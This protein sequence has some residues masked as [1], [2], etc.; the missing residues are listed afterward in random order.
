MYCPV[1]TEHHTLWWVS[2]GFPGILSSHPVSVGSFRADNREASP[3]V[4]S[5]SRPHHKT[6]PGSRFHGLQASHIVLTVKLLSVR[7]MANLTKECLRS[8]VTGDSDRF[9]SEK[10]VCVCVC[11][12]VYMCVWLYDSVSTVYACVWTACVFSSEALLWHNNVIKRKTPWGRWLWLFY[13]VYGEL[14]GTTWSSIKCD[15]ADHNHGLESCCRTVIW[16]MVAHF[17]TSCGFNLT[18]FS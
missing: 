3:K 7:E 12:F 17:L 8:R 6:L 18:T 13:S 5:H 2:Q 11:L 15:L 16:M 1:V 10:W 9:M 4:C 14:L